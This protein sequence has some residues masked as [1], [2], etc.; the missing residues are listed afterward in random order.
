MLRPRLHSLSISISSPANSWRVPRPPTPRRAV[1]SS[2]MT[3]GP[4]ASDTTKPDVPPVPSVSYWEP[5]TPLYLDSP[6]LQVSSWPDSQSHQF[7]G[8]SSGVSLH[9]PHPPNLPGEEPLS[10]DWYRWAHLFHHVPISPLSPR[11]PR[12]PVQLY[13]CMPSCE[14]SPVCAKL[15]TFVEVAAPMSPRFLF[16]RTPPLPPPSP[17]SLFARRHST[18]YTTSHL[19]LC[20]TTD[21]RGNIKTMETPPSPQRLGWPDMASPVRLHFTRVGGESGEEKVAMRQ[22]RF[23][24]VGKG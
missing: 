13:S 15:P 16:P 2:T 8:A 17:A 22:K 14:A 12:S 24:G 11:S 20:G 5:D 21:D 10:P 7:S 1:S 9:D 23:K 4:S 18:P 19:V 6:T 3:V